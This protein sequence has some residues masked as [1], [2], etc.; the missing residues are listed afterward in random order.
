[1]IS[2]K[3][4]WMKRKSTYQID[5]WEG[6][7]GRAYTDRSILSPMCLDKLYV[8]TW[9]V[10][11]SQMIRDFLMPVKKNIKKVLEVGCNVGNQLNMLQKLGFQNLYGIEI[12]RYAIEKAKKLSKGIDIIRASAFDIPFK[13]RY[14]DLVFTAGVLIHIS[15]EDISRALDE[16]Y[17]CSKRYIWGFEYFAEDYT[18]IKYRGKS[19]LLWKTDFCKLYLDRFSDLNIIKEKKYKY[20]KNNKV[21]A[22]FLLEKK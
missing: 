22:M 11:R 15:P 13:D 21:D 19:N 20:I 16:I 4:V 17:R 7:F 12:Q 5:N 18:E 14:F 9:G 2:E 8:D 10:S 1:M 3:G 6:A